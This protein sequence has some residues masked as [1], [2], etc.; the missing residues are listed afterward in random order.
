[1]CVHIYTYPA[2][3]MVMQRCTPQK[4]NDTNFLRNSTET[5]II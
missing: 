2:G 5:S 1:M 4:V 3:I